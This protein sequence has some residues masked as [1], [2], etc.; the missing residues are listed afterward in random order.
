MCS[1]WGLLIFIGL[2]VASRSA[3]GAHRFSSL[4]LMIAVSGAAMFGLADV[5]FQSLTMAMS[6]MF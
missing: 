3:S 1:L 5:V 6:L 4:M 2:F